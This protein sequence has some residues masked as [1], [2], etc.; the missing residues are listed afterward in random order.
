MIEVM[1]NCTLFLL[2]GVFTGCTGIAYL[3]VLIPLVLPIPAYE[4]VLGGIPQLAQGGAKTPP[5]FI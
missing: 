1:L 3:Q 5:S 4:G 2:S